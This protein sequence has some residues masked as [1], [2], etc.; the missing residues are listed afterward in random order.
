MPYTDTPAGGADHGQS[1]K[2]PATYEAL[3]RSGKM[4]KSRA[5]AISNAAI[6]KGYKRGRHHKGRKGRKR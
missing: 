5:A 1:I 3:M 6:R 4:S 2:N